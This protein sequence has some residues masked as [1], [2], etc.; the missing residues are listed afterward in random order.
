MKTTEPIKKRL[1]VAIVVGGVIILLTG[2]LSNQSGLLGVNYWG[3]PL[4]WLK[5]VVYPDTPRVIRWDYFFLDWPFLG[6]YSFLRA[7]CN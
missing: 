3:Y 4:P 5:Q 1:I 7:L 6:R 2:L